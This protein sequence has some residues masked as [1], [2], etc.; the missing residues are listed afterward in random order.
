MIE[1]GSSFFVD[2]TVVTLAA[3]TVGMILEMLIPARDGVVSV[4]R[5]LNNTGLAL[6][7][8]ACNHFLGTFVAVFVIYRFEPISFT[9]LANVPLW[10]D[11]CI[12]FFVLELVRYGIH[13]AM[14]KL[15]VL[16]RF[17]AVHHSDSAVDVSTSFRHHPIEAVFSAVPITA[18]IWLL[19]GAL[20]SLILYRAWDLIM[21]VMTHTNVNVPMRLERWL[22]RLVVTPA[23]HRTRH[24]AERRCTDSNYGAS[25]PWFDYLFSTYQ[26]TSAAQQ[27][28]AKMGLDTHTSNEQRLDGMLRAPFMERVNYPERY[29]VSVLSLCLPRYDDVGDDRQGVT[30]A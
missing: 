7:T 16:W 19:G 27:K 30:G 23:F 6:I 12:V 15:P 29:G 18:V 24:F 8:Y 26:P 3:F 17:H 22:R 4:S 2:F 25:V 13:V 14:H 11:V 20:E 5:W 21:T 1:T 9:G 28:S 10:L